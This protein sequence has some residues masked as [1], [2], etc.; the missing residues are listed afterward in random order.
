MQA[1]QLG[2]ADTSNEYKQFV[3]KFKPK[4]TTDDCY[5]PDNVYEAVADWVANEYSLDRVNFIRPFYPG[6]DYE[7]ERYP[8]GCV[9]VDNPPF[10]ILSKIV[11]FYMAHGVKFFLFAPI[12]TIFGVTKDLGVCAVL[13]AADITYENGAIVSTSFVTNLEPETAARTSPALYNAVKKANDENAGPKPSLPKYKYPDH[14]MMSTNMADL[15]KQGIEF[16]VG[17]GEA[18]FVRELDS[19]K[20]Q[21]KALF[22]GGYLLSDN[23][24][25]RYKAAREKAAREKAAAMKKAIEWTLSD[26]ERGIIADL[27]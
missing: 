26:R 3:E 12:L 23:A 11:S 9:V 24:K 25:D 18:F 15:S 6:G 2:L 13:V 20:P 5:T 16:K 1:L 17:R 7:R 19:Q 27:S 14:V 8:E 21:K 4:K 10:S 22:G